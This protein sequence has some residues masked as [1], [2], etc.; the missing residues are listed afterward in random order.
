MLVYEVIVEHL[1]HGIH[2]DVKI[3]CKR[4]YPVVRESPKHY[5]VWVQ[6]EFDYDDCDLCHLGE[7][8]AE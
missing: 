7:P 4:C 2:K 6:R 1:P 3:L 5:A 8:F